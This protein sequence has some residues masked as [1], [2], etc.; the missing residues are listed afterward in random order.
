VIVFVDTTPLPHWDETAYHVLLIVGYDEDSV[1][2]ND[3]FIE[4]A[5][6]STPI[7]NFLD[8]WGATDNYMAV[9]KKKNV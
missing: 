5:E 4:Q 9:I 8:A 3:P 6:I 7:A 2:I 1:I